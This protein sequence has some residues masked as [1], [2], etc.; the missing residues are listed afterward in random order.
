MAQLKKTGPKNRFLLARYSYLEYSYIEGL[1][2]IQRRQ[3]RIREL[4]AQRGQP[5]DQKEWEAWQEQE[6]E[7][8]RQEYERQVQ[9]RRKQEQESFAS[10]Y[11]M[12]YN[13]CGRPVEYEK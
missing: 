2:Y 13:I 8:E 5:V 1:L 11:A 4:R 7:R 6:Q 12:Q 10:E 3:E 9:E